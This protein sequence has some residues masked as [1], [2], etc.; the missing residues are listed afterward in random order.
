MFARMF[1]PSSLAS[2]LGHSEYWTENS[3][4]ASQIDNRPNGTYVMA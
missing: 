3:D 2:R 4:E 1:D